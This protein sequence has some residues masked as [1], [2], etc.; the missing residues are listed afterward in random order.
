MK[1]TFGIIGCIFLLLYSGIV[2][3]V[4]TERQW[5]NEFDF[6]LINVIQSQVSDPLSVLV[7]I[8]TDIG[9]VKEIIAVT[10]LVIAVLWIKRMYVAGLWLGGTV[11]LSVGLLTVM[12][13]LIGRARPDILVIATEQSQSFPS[14]HSAVST[15]FYGLIGL[16]MVL[17]MKKLWHKVFI[18]VIVS[19]IISFVT[20]SRIYLG[21][22]FPTDVLGG[23]FFGLAG[24]F[25]SISMYQL[26]LPHLQKFLLQM[27]LKDKSPLLMK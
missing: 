18:T 12:K 25:I 5:V 27:K 6:L 11:L 3:G 20:L 1:K 26:T 22:H 2:L 17:L 24:V 13:I 9:G 4:L 16:T 21:A 10:I 14:G 23:L 8:L 15:I 19:M 7:A